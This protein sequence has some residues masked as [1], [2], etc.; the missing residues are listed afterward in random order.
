MVENRQKTG[1]DAG[2]PGSGLLI[3]HIDGNTIASKSLTNEVNDSECYPP[4]SCSTDHYGVALVQAD[5][6][7]FWSK[8]LTWEMLA[9]PTLVQI[10]HLFQIIPY[11]NSKLYNGNE[12]NVSITNISTTGSTMT[13]TMSVTGT[14]IPTQLQHQHSVD[15]GEY[16]LFSATTSYLDIKKKKRE[17]VT[18]TTSE[19]TVTENDVAIIKCPAEGMTV[20][21]VVNNKGKEA[22]IGF[23]NERCN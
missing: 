15:C 22:H 7:W 23:T 20:T 14:T 12:S 10:M 17:N 16:N 2:L 3:W 6:Q 21:A 1:F 13:A 19:G 8:I 11:P 18:V 5:G 4:L 9:I